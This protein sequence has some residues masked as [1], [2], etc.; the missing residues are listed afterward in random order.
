MLQDIGGYERY[1]ITGFIFL[2]LKGRILSALTNGESYQGDNSF[3]G[4]K[5][6]SE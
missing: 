1:V 2:V 3:G 5:Q 4:V 6:S